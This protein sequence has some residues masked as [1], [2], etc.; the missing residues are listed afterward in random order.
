MGT[1]MV[2]KKINRFEIGIVR[3][4]PQSD[5]DRVVETLTDYRNKG[6][7]RFEDPEITESLNEVS[8]VYDV[9]DDSEKYFT[10]LRE[11]DIRELRA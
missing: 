8:D 1:A 7:I 10:T 11:Q 9:V 5:F 6:W 3:D 2:I 4:L